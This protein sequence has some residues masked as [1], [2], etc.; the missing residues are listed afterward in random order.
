VL[1]W[2]AAAVM[3][4]STLPV[5]PAKAQAVAYCTAAGVPGGCVARPASRAAV[6]AATP[7]VVLP[8]WAW[9]L[10]WVP[11]HGAWAWHQRR[12]RA[13]APIGAGRSTVP[14]RAEARWLTQARRQGSR[15]WTLHLPDAV[16]RFRP[17]EAAAMPPNRLRQ[18]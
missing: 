5:L 18:A 7:G 17:V 8:A 13:A 1:K 6:R 10:A 3:A 4:A 14:V 12:V 15:G 11:A 16:S 2:F 9:R